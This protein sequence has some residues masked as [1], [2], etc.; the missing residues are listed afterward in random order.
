MSP[1]PEQVACSVV[2]T[3]LAPKLKKPLSPYN[4]TI[5]KYYI[6]KSIQ[7]LEPV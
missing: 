4:T 2:S 1:V 7:S 3:T 5:N 6:A